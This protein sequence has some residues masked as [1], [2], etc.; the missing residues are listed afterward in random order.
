MRASSIA[1]WLQISR[2]T[3]FSWVAQGRVPPGIRLTSGTVVW[4]IDEVAAALSVKEA[5]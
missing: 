1:S 5:R 3:W 2:S 4:D